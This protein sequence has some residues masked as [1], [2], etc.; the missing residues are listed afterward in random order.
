MPLSF[1]CDIAVRASSPYQWEQIVSVSGK[2]CVMRE[3]VSNAWSYNM[4]YI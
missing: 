4:S 3:T 1:Y 2:K